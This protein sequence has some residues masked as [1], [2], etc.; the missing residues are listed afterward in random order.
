MRSAAAS[1]SQ[2]TKK[3]QR[4]LPQHDHGGCKVISDTGAEH[5]STDPLDP[6]LH[7]QHVARSD[8]SPIRLAFMHLHKSSTKVSLFPTSFVDLPV[9]EEV[10][11]PG[12]WGQRAGG[13]EELPPEGGGG[14]GRGGLQE[15]PCA[16]PAL[17]H[18]RLQTCRQ[19]PCRGSQTNT[20]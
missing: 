12:R 10:K 7:N 17:C 19:I 11:L 13:Q 16:Q 8:S 4:Y 1:G 14:G 5:W 6:V 2:W 15:P 20:R 3:S 9:P 18:P